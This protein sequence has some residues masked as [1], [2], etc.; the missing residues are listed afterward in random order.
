M[1]TVRIGIAGFGTVGQATASILASHQA[2]IAA[3]CGAVLCV[4]AICRRSPIAS[5]PFAVKAHRDWRELVASP[6]V[7]IVLETMGGVTDARALVATALESGKPVVTANK[8]LLAAE[9]E[10]LMKIAD[11]RNVPLG[12]EAAVA[13]G[14]PVIRAIAEGTA[15]DRLRS[16]HGILNGTANYILTRMEAGVIEFADALGEAQRLGYAEADPS[17]DVD[18]IDARDK[19]AILARLAFGGK[20]DANAIATTGIRGL[21]AIDMV[22]A[23]KLEGTIRLVGAAEKHADGVALTVRPWLVSHRDLLAKVEGVNNAVILEGERAGVQMF[24]GPGAGGDATAIAVL[25]DLMEIAGDMASGRLGAKPT[26]GFRE[27]TDVPLCYQPPPVAWYLR[28][29][30]ED[31]P[32]VL[33]RLA[34]VLARHEINIDRVLQEPNLDKRR[35]PFVITVEPVS[36]PLLLRAVAELDR[37]PAVKAPALPLRM[38]A[39]E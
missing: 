21:T 17:F 3:R 19:L 27:T 13:G 32:G 26:A 24:Y 20:V 36:E 16:V 18:G 10:A 35:L 12:F 11:R 6:E 2:E 38:V 39:M 28:L 14:V 37:D 4:T 30:I 29:V 15:A 22:Y 31:A 9:G 33:A 7:D 23:A 5:P 1:R 34:G 8:N 25:S